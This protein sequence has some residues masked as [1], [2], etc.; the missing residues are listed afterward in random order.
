MFELINVKQYYKKKCFLNINNLTLPDKGIVVIKGF[1]GSGKS[2]F[3]NLI[4]GFLRYDGEIKYRGRDIK[5]LGNSLFKDVCY[6]P[7][8]SILFDSL[9]VADNLKANAY[10]KGE[11]ANI[12][13]N[14]KRIKAMSG[15]QAKGANLERM[16]G[17]SFSTYIL[18][19]PST[20]LDKVRKAELIA[21]LR[22]EANDKLII[23][24]T[25]DEDLMDI[26]KTTIEID[27]INE[28]EN[29][30][31]A[32]K[33]IEVVEEKPLHQLG[34]LFKSSLGLILAKGIIMLSLFIAS[35]VLLSAILTDIEELKANVIRNTTNYYEIYEGYD[36]KIDINSFKEGG[37]PYSL[38]SLE[39]DLVLKGN[40]KQIL[41]HKLYFT[42]NSED[43]VASD[44][45]SYL[46]KANSF[47]IERDTP[48]NI[49]PTKIDKTSYNEVLGLSGF[50]EYLDF[51]C[52]YLILPIGYIDSLSLATRRAKAAQPSSEALIEGF[53]YY[54]YSYAQ[55][56]GSIGDTLLIEK[57][58]LI[59]L[60]I[61]LVLA[62]VYIYLYENGSTK[63]FYVAKNKLRV[64]SASRKYINTYQMIGDLIA[65]IPSLI[66]AIVA[67][68]LYTPIMNNRNALLIYET[69][70][71]GIFSYD[72]IPFIVIS[73]LGAIMIAATITIKGI[74]NKND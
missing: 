21:Y 70:G 27:K 52:S 35:F 66:L 39:V 68:L 7:Q 44:Y 46:L 69:L 2:T 25:H 51:Q 53:S 38:I 16:K 59:P 23:I 32:Y 64:F 11:D 55:A 34:K 58:V 1:N 40:D 61:L 56:L 71:G 12:G 45:I 14:P 30:N 9:S 26:A 4:L 63:S 74:G 60:I 49:N 72:A 20:S 62:L 28:Y 54:N 67:G 6:I 8:F 43:I 13:D 5:E 33:S 24:A 37:T 57:V 29:T 22:E 65:I 17:L 41:L 15:G 36:E 18:D 19:E 3:L 31:I 73:L 42:N 50:E 47:T 10:L 48:I